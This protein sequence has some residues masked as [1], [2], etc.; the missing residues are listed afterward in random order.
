[1]HMRIYWGRVGQ[2]D[3]PQIAERYAALMEKAPAGML[4]RFVTRDENDPENMFTVTLWS[5]V[6][7]VRAWESS[8][9]YRDLYLAAISPFIVASQSVSL[10]E[11]MTWDAGRLVEAAQRQA[12]G[13]ASGRGS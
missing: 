1:M 8:D 13:Q 10:C 2:R 6:D 4:A 3:W 12:S 9:E 11:V 5:D 7:S